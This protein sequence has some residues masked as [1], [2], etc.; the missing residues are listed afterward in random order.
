MGSEKFEREKHGYAQR[1]IQQKI[2]GEV[3]MIS[4][5]QLSD[6]KNFARTEVY[7]KHLHL[8][9]FSLII[10]ANASGKTNIREA[11]R[12][13][14]G[15]SRGY[16]LAEI[17]G[18]KYIGGE[19][20]WEGIRGGIKEVFFQDSTAKHPAFTI[21]VSFIGE[22]GKVY[23][24]LACIS[25]SFRQA[26]PFVFSEH[27]MCTSTI[28]NRNNE[29]EVNEDSSELYQILIPKYDS[30]LKAPHDIKVQVRID[31][32]HDDVKTLSFARHRP[33]LTQLASHWEVPDYLKEAARSVLSVFSSMHFLDLH[34]EAMRIPSIPGQRVLSDR[35]EN[36]SSV[37]LG[38]CEDPERKAS[39]IEWLRELTPMDV[40][41]LEFPADQTGKVLVSLV[42]S[43]G[44]K[45]SAYSASDG[46][47]RFLGMIAAL[48][49]PEPARFYFLE[50]IENGIHPSRLHLL[51]QLIEQTVENSNIQVV[52]TTH[53]P[54]VLA[55]VN[56]K[57]LENS[58]LVYRLPNSKGAN[59]IRLLDVPEIR[60]VLETQDITKLHSSGWL[61]DAV[62]LAT[63]NEEQ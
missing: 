9:K 7:P 29:N 44:Q 18:E 42:E 33:I 24:Y 59:I 2:S 38:I 39:L 11:F 52:A 48:L 26:G 49:A 34:P 46:T 54:Y 14:H 60:H 16:E 4:N 27:L 20:V 36:L 35:G 25:N 21:G 5:L 22:D 45:I 47:L 15:I 1:Y 61:E 40:V 13:L 62:T 50:E 12:F 32:N 8:S 19:I 51:M 55:L 37:L 53:S 31:P 56:Q 10:G 30:F 41:D 3:V 58:S 17:F 63:P 23:S 28:F 6:F 43:G 57:T